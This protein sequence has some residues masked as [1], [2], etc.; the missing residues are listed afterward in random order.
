MEVDEK[1]RDAIAREMRKAYAERK[2]RL[3]GRK[4]KPNARHQSFAHWQRAADQALR[5]D[6]PAEAYIYAAF[7]YCKMSTGPF[8]NNLAGPAAVGWWSEYMLHNPGYREERKQLE[9]AGADPNLVSGVT[10]AITEIKQDLQHL[11]TSLFRMTNEK[12]WPPLGPKSLR[13]VRSEMLPMRPHM[14]MILSYPDDVV[15][16]YYGKE[17]LQN[18]ERRPEI[19]RAMQ[20]LGFDTLELLQWLRQE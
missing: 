10:P 19:L 9:E 16:K 20:T 1:M 12:D 18:F 13:V 8:P 6:A 3:L 17:I 4:W 5:L 7:A 14:R 15:L 11:R 2:S